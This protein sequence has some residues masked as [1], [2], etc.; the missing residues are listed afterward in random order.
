MPRS[1]ALWMTARVASRLIRPPKLLQPR[2]MVETRRPDWPRFRISI[3]FAPAFH[4]GEP[5]QSRVGLSTS[6]RQGVGKP[7]VA[8]HTARVRDGSGGAAAATAVPR[9]SMLALVG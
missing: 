7:G 5:C 8:Q 2:P 6:A 4:S 3:G 9:A 1:I